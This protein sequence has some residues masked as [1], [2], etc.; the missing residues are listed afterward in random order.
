MQ[1]L[2]PCFS[3]CLSYGSGVTGLASAGHHHPVFFASPLGGLPQGPATTGKA[4]GSHLPWAAARS[5]RQVRSPL[6]AAWCSGK[7][8]SSVSSV[9]AWPS[10]SNHSTRAGCPNRAARCNGETPVASWSCGDTSRTL[11]LCRPQCSLSG[12]HQHGQRQLPEAGLLEDPITPEAGSFP[13][14][15]IPYRD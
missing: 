11:S 5:F 9:A 14:S 8:P 4:L 1:S 10:R 13:A 12:Q 7:A 3:P 15:S 2:H 6:T